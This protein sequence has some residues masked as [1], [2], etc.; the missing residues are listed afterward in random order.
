[1][2][3]NSKT[4]YFFPEILTAEDFEMLVIAEKS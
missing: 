4:R 2:D 3:I 1:M